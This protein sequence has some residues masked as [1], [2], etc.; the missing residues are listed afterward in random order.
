MEDTLLRRN[1]ESYWDAR[2]ECLMKRFA[3]RAAVGALMKYNQ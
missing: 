1:A 2:R 3:Q